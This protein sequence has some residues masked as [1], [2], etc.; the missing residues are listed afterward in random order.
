MKE[1]E[2]QDA[3]AKMRSKIEE[4]QRDKEELQANMQEMKEAM[5]KR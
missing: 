5:K 1:K 2:L 3:L 4:A